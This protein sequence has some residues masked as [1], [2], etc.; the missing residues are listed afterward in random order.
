[1]VYR[2]VP[3]AFIFVLQL[4]SVIAIAIANG[5][6]IAADRPGVQQP[7]QPL[8]RGRQMLAVLCVASVVA[9]GLAA[10]WLLLLRSGARMLIWAGAGGGC[11]LALVNGLWLLAQGGAAGTC[12]GLLSLLT[13]AGC[14]LFIVLNRQRV[15]FS[16]HL[17]TT[18]AELTREYPGMVWVAVGAAL[19]L[20]LWMLIWS[21]AV[22]YTSNLPAQGSVL[23]LLLISLIWTAQL[24]KAVV[25]ATVAGTVAS[26]YFLSPN[27]PKSPTVRSLRRA[28]TTS[29]GSLCL[30]SLVAASLKSMR[31]ASRAVST[32]SSGSVR[33]CALCCLGFLDVLTRFFNELAYPQGERVREGPTHCIHLMADEQV[34]DLRWRV[35]GVVDDAPLGVDGAV[36]PRD[37]SH[38]LVIRSLS[39][40]G[41][42]ALKCLH[43][44]H[45]RGSPKT[46]LPVRLAASSR[47]SAAPVA[48]A[49]S[50]STA[51]HSRAPR[52][53][54]GRCWCTTREWTPWSSVS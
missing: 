51:R 38:I 6:S 10:F 49:Q 46:S 11:V 35:V 23:F 52:V 16:A 2:D 32:R 37:P 5:I 15:E 4:L 21:A 53:T 7:S 47:H 36:P 40:L 1:M 24:L 12:L 41:K 26:W 25:N 31:A 9:S 42:L 48:C 43:A 54:R 44:S 33:A 50:P 14:V 3:F 45:G 13:G 28:L 19:L 20:L 39:A 29:F 17:L 18:V 30:G 34:A 8:T 22:A 27:V